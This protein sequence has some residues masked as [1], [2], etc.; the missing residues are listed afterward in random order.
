MPQFTSENQP[1]RRGTAWFKTKIVESLKRN[2]MSEEDF[3]DLLVKKAVDEGGVFLSELLKRYSPPPKP[4]LPAIE[5]EFEPDWSPVKK[6]DAI[7]KEVS[8]GNVSP[9]VGGVLIDAIAKMLNIEETTE[10]AKRLEALE[11]IIAEKA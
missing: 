5:F 1:S 11:K 7:M 4:T 10:L 6:A 2:S 9:D 8:A 3:I